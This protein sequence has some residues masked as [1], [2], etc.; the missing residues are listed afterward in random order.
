MDIEKAKEFNLLKEDV[1]DF[2]EKSNNFDCQNRRLEHLIN[3]TF[4]I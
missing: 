1:E 4:T 2:S 3:L